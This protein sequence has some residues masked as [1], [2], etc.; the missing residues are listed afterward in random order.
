MDKDKEFAFAEKLYALRNIERFFK[1]HAWTHDPRPG[2]LALYGKKDPTLPFL[3][4]PKQLELVHQLVENIKTGKDVLIE[5]SR[6]LGVSWI[7]ITVFLWFWL[8]PEPGN[9][10]LLGSRKFE[11]VDKKGA[12]D[13][14]FQ[15]FRYNLY[16]LHREFLPKGW[17]QN[18]NDNIGLITNPETGS[19]IRGEANNANFGTSGRYK[20][21]LLDEFA[22]WEE[23]DSQAWTSVGDSSPCRIAVST[24]W[25]MGRKFAQLRYSGAIDVLTFHWKEHPLKSAGLFYGQHPVI[26]EKK[27]VPLSD[28]YLKECERRKDNARENIGQELDI[29]YLSSG[30]PYFNNE[31]LQRRYI[32]LKNN[33]YK[34]YSFEVTGEKI[35]LIEN[36]AGSIVIAEPMPNRDLFV[37]Y[38]YQITADVAQGL[39]KGDYSV[40][41]V[42][43][44]VKKRDVA[45]YRGHC[46]TDIFALLLYHFSKKYKDAW[47]QVENNNNGH[48]VIQKLKTLTNRIGYEQDYAEWIDIENAKLG[49][50]TNV[51]T[52]PVMLATLREAIRTGVDGIQEA[53][54]FTEAMTFITNKN[55][56]A[57]ADT[58]CYDDRVIAQAIKFMFHQWLPA[59]KR[60]EELEDIDY[61]IYDHGRYEPQKKSLIDH[62]GARFV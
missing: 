39:E 13:T 56:K 24:P 8:Q 58:G 26:P 48:A 61:G 37:D 27:N 21:A 15:K 29:D 50:N 57:E 10:F 46:D 17:D 20:A 38:R 36:S 6:D 23:T 2:I 44:R 32:E 41:Y 4:F 60:Q 16:Y 22:K 30:T 43:D 53:E 52:R 3:L 5:K 49:W 51:Q 1:Y 12:Q 47:I 45:W 42:Y 18:V 40:F 59:P 11:Y 62:R 35:R 34:R 33:E 7:V 14:L 9:D 28:W 55:G 31:I 19:Y 54:F 25:G